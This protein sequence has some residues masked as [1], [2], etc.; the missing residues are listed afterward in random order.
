ML[1]EEEIKTGG[2]RAEN[3]NPRQSCGNCRYSGNSVGARLI[4]RRKAPTVVITM[5]QVPHV[6]N[7][8][9]FNKTN[10][11]EMHTIWPPIHESSWCGDWAEKVIIKKDGDT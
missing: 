2:Q 4:C 9:L 3:T 5:I 8:Q 10:I 11:N 1:T 6:I 7:N